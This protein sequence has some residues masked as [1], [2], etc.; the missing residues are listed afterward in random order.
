MITM[1][2]IFTHYITYMYLRQNSAVLILQLKEI[3][4]GSPSRDTKYNRNKYAQYIKIRMVPV[5]DTK[6]RVLLHLPEKKK[7]RNLM[8]TKRCTYSLAYSIHVKVL[9]ACMNGRA[10]IVL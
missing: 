9:E 4:Y 5:V 8:S 7:L 10:C 3:N 2:Y 6:S 1:V